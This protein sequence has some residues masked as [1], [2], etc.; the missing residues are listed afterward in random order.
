[1]DIAKLHSQALQELSWDGISTRR[2]QQRGKMDE[3][4][5][6]RAAPRLEGP[7]SR[8]DNRVGTILAGRYRILGLLGKG[9][10][11]SVYVGEHLK[12]GRKDAIKILRPELLEDSEAVARFTRGAS[13]ASY[14]SHPN[15]CTVYDFGDTEDGLPFMASELVDGRELQEIMEAQG[16]FSL[17]RAVDLVEQIAAALQAAHELGIIHRDLKPAN[18]MIRRS[19]DGREAVKVVDFDIA[20]GIGE[21]EASGVTRAGWVIGTPR[22]MSPEQITAEDLDRRSDIY[23]LGLL[24]FEMLTGALPHDV[25]SR[26]R[27]MWARV[28]GD[29]STLKETIPEAQFPPGLQEILN[30]ALSRNRDGRPATAREFARQL[31]AVVP[32]PKPSAII[33]EPA[34]SPADATEIF[35][36]EQRARAR[37]RQPLVRKS[38]RLMLAA[39]GAAGALVLGAS[40]S[41]GKLG[42]VPP[43][44]LIVRG[45]IHVERGAT[46]SLEAL[47]VDSERGEPLAAEI[48]YG[49]TD[50]SIAV[51][52][53]AGVVRGLAVG[54]A[55]VTV[56]AAGLTRHIN[57][58]VTDSL[59]GHLE[60][61]ET[62]GVAPLVRW[63]GAEPG[64]D[65]DLVGETPE[66]RRP[67]PITASASDEQT[68]EILDPAVA[69]TQIEMGNW[70]VAEG[71]SGPAVHILTRFDFDSREATDWCL[72]A[73]YRHGGNFLRSID[74]ASNLGKVAA[75]HHTLRSRSGRQVGEEILS[76]PIEHLEI[77]L[78]R[79]NAR[80][81]L[82]VHLGAWPKECAAVAADEVPLAESAVPVT[83]CLI[84]SAVGI[85]ADPICRR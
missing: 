76:I 16:R 73:R 51:V 83:I 54:S 63:P 47:L 1:M 55:S 30:A 11:G 40:L 21:A 72:A 75:A 68:E 56:S 2:N 46:Q 7:A 27:L 43:P 10:Q 37:S 35:D 3:Q 71:A 53:G 22:Y 31:R 80:A 78:E 44:T 34:G 14:I 12:I 8:P 18:V 79:L 59:G 23:S 74:S 33:P 32:A 64:R 67:S 77:P 42:N 45:P 13:K 41:L 19:S 62:A 52:D 84:R 69:A 66:P 26:Q 49:T 39:A 25:S 65:S 15:V 48:S 58:I 20:K 9:A 5:E 85:Q 61:N 6:T 57:V 29:L 17:E 82:G 60:S 70:T 28:N 24:F 50:S 81:Q 38:Y 4:E 36:S